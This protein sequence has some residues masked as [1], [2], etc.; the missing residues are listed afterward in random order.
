MRGPVPCLDWPRSRCADLL[1]GSDRRPRPLLERRERL[2]ELLAGADQA[3]QF[4]EAIVADGR[5]VF[6]AAER[7]GVEG[8]VLQSCEWVLRSV[9]LARVAEDEVHGGGG[10]C[11]GRR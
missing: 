1:N 7:L 10:V 4:S 3:L 2:T 11:G 8:I 9:S 6:A 5:K